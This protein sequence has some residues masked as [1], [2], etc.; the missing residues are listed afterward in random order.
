MTARRPLLTL[1]EA[2]AY[3]GCSE[4]N[5]RNLVTG[6]DL[7]FINV[8]V[9]KCYRIDPND[10]DEFIESRRQQNEP[11]KLRQPRPRLKHIRL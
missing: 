10:L 8:G 2:A 9:R 7:P 11:I 1:K 4:E 3:L 5:V 6:G